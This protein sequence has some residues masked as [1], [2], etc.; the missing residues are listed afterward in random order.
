MILTV[1][2]HG[3][4]ADAASDY[5]RRLTARGEEDVARA[6]H[7]LAAACQ[8]RKISP[9]DVLCCSPWIRTMA[10]ADILSITLPAALAE[11]VPAL[12]PG[13]K[14][15]DVE[16]TLEERLAAGAPAEHLLLVSHQPLVSRLINHWLDEDGRVPPLN[17]GAF[18]SLEMDIP[19]RG[20]A[21]L[22]FWAMPP[23]CEPVA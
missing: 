22:L 14:M 9:P 6:G 4:A 12:Q 5:A 13:A 16:A 21:R 23:A 17:P 19:A 2:R 11:V 8:Q 20:C 18:A 1:F 7:A 15:R 10:T 3:E